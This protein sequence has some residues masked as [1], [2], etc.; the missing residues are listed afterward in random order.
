[1]NTTAREA[2]TA[3]VHN[4]GSVLVWMLQLSLVR[5]YKV[6]QSRVYADYLAPTT[7]KVVPQRILR[8]REHI[9][10]HQ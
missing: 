3:R 1:M 8:V 5:T 2:I 4:L 6:L 7:S 10:M 9:L